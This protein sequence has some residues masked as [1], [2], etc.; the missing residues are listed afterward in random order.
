M[1]NL[2]KSGI[3][4]STRDDSIADIV[5]K[6][7]EEDLSSKEQSDS[8]QKDRTWTLQHVRPLSFLCSPIPM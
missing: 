5:S 1:L 2:D 4:D 6:N 7:D 3:L 8:E